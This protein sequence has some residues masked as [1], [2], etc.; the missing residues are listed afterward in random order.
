MAGVVEASGG[1]QHR[2]R[3]DV[4]GGDGEL[5]GGDPVGDDGGA[6][7]DKVADV[8]GG[9]VAGL[10]EQGPVGGEQLRVVVRLDPL[11]LEQAASPACS[12]PDAGPVAAAAAASGWW[13][14]ANHRSVTASRNAALLEK[15]R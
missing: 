13:L 8:R 3:R 5:T 11:G 6:L 4:R 1:A 2:P 12:R 10:R 7:A 15:C 14:R 9:H